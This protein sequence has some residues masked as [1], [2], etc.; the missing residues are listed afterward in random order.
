MLRILISNDDGIN[1]IGIKKLVEATL[2]LSDVEVYV[3]APSEEK[4]GVGHGITYRTPLTSAVHSFYGLPVQ[5]WEVHG[6][7]ADCVKAA[8]YLLLEEDRRPDIVFSGINV[9]NNLGRDVY[10]SG[11]CSA[12]REA[13]ILGI[14]SVAFSYDNY[15]AGDDYGEVEEIVKPLLREFQRRAIEKLLPPEVFWNVNIPNLPAAEVKGIA[16]APLS[17]YHYQDKYKHASEGYYLQREYPETGDQEKHDYGMLQAGY[18]TVTPIH[19]DSTDYTLLESMGD[20][21]IIK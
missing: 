18:V 2:T 10:Y 9:G 17:L 4:S 6:T 15:F 3:A 16:P 19:I 11:T 7:P 5:A 20:W 14:P 12:A 21:P 13:V 8:Y 1:A